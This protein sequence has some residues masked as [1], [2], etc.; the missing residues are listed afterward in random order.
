[1][2]DA[3]II[4]RVA[5][6]KYLLLQGV[7]SLSAGGPFAAGIAVLAFHDATEMLLGAIAEHLHAP[8]KDQIAFA[9]LMDASD[10]VGPG[11]LTHRPALLQLNR[12]RVMFK[13]HGLEP[14]EEDVA[15]YRATLDAF[16]PVSVAGFLG[17]DYERVTLTELIQHTRSRNWLRGAE[18]YFAASKYADSIFNAAVA[19]KIALKKKT[20]RI[21]PDSLVTAA[22]YTPADHDYSGVM[23]LV[24]TAKQVEARFRTVDQNLY[25]IGSGVKYSEIQ[26]F[27]DL[28]PD[29]Y[30]TADQTPGGNF[31]QGKDF[32]EEE[33]QFC[34]SFVQ[35]TILKIQKQY[36]TRERLVQPRTVGI[37]RFVLDAPLIVYP[38]DPKREPEVLAQIP[39]GSTLPACKSWKGE[40]GGFTEVLFD[41]E[42]A[43]VADSLVE[44]VAES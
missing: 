13:H 39:A 11:K 3:A 14:R 37:V 40:K 42:I 34:I 12:S 7:D 23:A 30:F 31:S 5:C 2:V 22:Q 8:I 19:L 21:N 32:S 28:E 43:Y 18:E 27:R 17:I 4:R 38:T 35:D 24:E 29:L 26:R 10:Q 41:G 36:S 33:A 9:A 1:M 20:G 44:V 16:F 6:A 25:L 15:K